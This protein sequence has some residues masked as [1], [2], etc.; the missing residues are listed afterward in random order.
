MQNEEQA[1]KK[2]PKPLDQPSG[3]L[4]IFQENIAPYSIK[5]QHLVS[6]PSRKGDIYVGNDG[7]NFTNLKLGNVGQVLTVK[8]G[9]PSWANAMLEGVAADRPTSGEFTGQIYAATDTFAV[10]IWF[11]SAWKSSTFS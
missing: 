8:D 2:Q 4:F 6:S 11:G 10:S 9:M 5:Q 7:V 3:N 1:S